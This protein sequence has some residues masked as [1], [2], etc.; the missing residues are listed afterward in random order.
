MV[1]ERLRALRSARGYTQEELEKRS[2]GKVDIVSAVADEELNA[3]AQTA[4]DI[5]AEIRA[6][7]RAESAAAEIIGAARS[8]A[9]FIGTLEPPQAKSAMQALVK[10]VVIPQDERCLPEIIL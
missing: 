7:R 10:T 2:G 5:E 8:F 1:G 6:E 3:L 4:R 9:D